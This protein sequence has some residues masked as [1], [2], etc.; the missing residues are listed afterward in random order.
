MPLL[1][2]GGSGAGNPV[3]GTGGIGQTLNYVG[4]FVYAYSGAVEN[5][6]G[7]SGSPST[8]LEFTTGSEIIDAK[9]YFGVQFAGANDTYFFIK[10]NDQ[11][12]MGITFVETGGG[13]NLTGNPIEFVIPPFSKVT[14]QWSIDGVT[15]NGFAMLSGRLH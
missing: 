3:G 11:Q 13:D 12:T 10:V 15:K 7:G 4:D 1:G 14:I 9:L 6:A 2:G 5:A 8:M